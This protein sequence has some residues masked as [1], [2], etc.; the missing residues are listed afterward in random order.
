MGNPINFPIKSD[1]YYYFKKRPEELFQERL[2][3]KFVAQLG[4]TL[5][6]VLCWVPFHAPQIIFERKKCRNLQR[7][8][9][10]R[11]GFGYPQLVAFTTLQSI[12]LRWAPFQ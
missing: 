12:I 4:T 11:Y 10:H 6:V 2:Q 8:R 1:F 7:N 9:G 5:S 3:F